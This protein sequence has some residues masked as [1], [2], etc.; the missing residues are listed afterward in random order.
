[1]A[2]RRF[3]LSVG[4]SLENVTEAVG[5]ATAADNVELTVDIASTVVKEGGSTRTIYR[6]EVLI[7][8]NILSQYITRVQWPPA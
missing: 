5:S 3:G 4:E 7:I 8:L 2:T 1:M 6:E